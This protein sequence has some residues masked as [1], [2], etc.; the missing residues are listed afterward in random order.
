MSSKYIVLF[1]LLTPDKVIA[2]HTERI[3]EAGGSCVWH[4]DMPTKGY[5]VE[6]HDKVALPFVYSGH[7]DI[8]SIEEVHARTHQ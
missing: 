6:I 2:E 3:R 8:I 5:D 1:K 7:P 4:F